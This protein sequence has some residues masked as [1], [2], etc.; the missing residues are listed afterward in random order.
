[1]RC[2]DCDAVIGLRGMTREVFAFGDGQRWLLGSSPRCDVLIRD[3]YVSPVHCG[4]ARRADGRLIVRD[5]GSRN[6]TI[7]DGQPV[8]VAELR[9]GSYLTIG[10]TTLVAI[11]GPRRGACATID[12]FRRDPVVRD[13]IARAAAGHA[14]ITGEPGT[15]KR[16]LARLVH[17]ASKPSGPLVTMRCAAVPRSLAANELFGNNASRGEARFLD[18]NAELSSVDQT[19][20]FLAEARGG[21]VILDEIGELPGDVQQRLAR[22]LELG[23]HD[24]VRII[25]TTSANVSRLQELRDRFAFELALPPLRERVGDIPQLVASMLAEHGRTVSADAWRELTAYTWPGNLR[26]LRAAVERAVRLGAE[27]LEPHDFFPGAR[28]DQEI[29]GA[30]PKLVRLGAPQRSRRRRSRSGGTEEQDVE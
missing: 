25:A 12:A 9:P 19:T 24:D 2:F 13:A 30:T 26:E 6:G 16:L 10:R 1:M 15:G 3:P 29:V 18:E 4:I 21:T 20:G 11:G 5:R 7:V 27:V 14:L 22:A 8:I 28:R 23:L 17:E